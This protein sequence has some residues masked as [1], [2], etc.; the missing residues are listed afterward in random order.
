[1]NLDELRRE[2][3]KY[4]TEDLVPAR[5]GLGRAKLKIDVGDD[6]G[7]MFTGIGGRDPLEY[8]RAIQAAEARNPESEFLASCRE[9]FMQRG[10]LTD[11]QLAALKQIAPSRGWHQ[12]VARLQAGHKPLPAPQPPPKLQRRIRPE[13][14]DD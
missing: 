11:K 1:M 4:L 7:A 13:L 2:A 14:M 12:R 8:A 10:F 9:F 5:R 3:Q 6:L